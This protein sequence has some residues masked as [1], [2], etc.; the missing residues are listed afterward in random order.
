[1]LGSEGL[2]SFGKVAQTIAVIAQRKSIA[3]KIGIENMNPTAPS[4]RSHTPAVTGLMIACRVWLAHF[5]ESCS[6]LFQ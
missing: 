4:M 5:S 6:L 3:P 1:M 2:D